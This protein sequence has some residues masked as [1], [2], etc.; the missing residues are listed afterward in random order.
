M[1][2][3]TCTNGHVM[4]GI[5]FD[6]CP[7]C[8]APWMTTPTV[9]EIV[10]TLAMALT[11]SEQGHYDKNEAL[12]RDTIS[13]L[14][15]NTETTNTMTQDTPTEQ[16]EADARSEAYTEGYKIGYEE[17]VKAERERCKNLV[18]SHLRTNTYDGNDARV[19]KTTVEE[20]VELLKVK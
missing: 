13:P 17:G 2:T 11:H 6:E 19:F 12:V 4:T 7:E 5:G 16:A 10:R 8:E 15:S 1:T 14:V 20:V 18:L 9:E 3:K